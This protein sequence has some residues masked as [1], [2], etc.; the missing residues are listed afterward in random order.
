MS[1]IKLFTELLKNM[2]N[3]YDNNTKK[4]LIS[5]NKIIFKRF[6]NYYIILLKNNKLN[7]FLEII[8]HLKN[9]EPNI[10]YITTEDILFFNNLITNN[11]ILSNNIDLNEFILLNNIKEKITNKNIFSQFINDIKHILVNDHIETFKKIDDFFDNYETIL[12]KVLKKG[13][14][15]NGPFFDVLQ[16]DNNKI[17]EINKILDNYKTKKK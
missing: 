7:S 13:E 12:C 6:L 15:F 11:I 5:Y 9:I 1:E 17:Q 4:T 8:N 10:K 16:V 2:C 14:N 3:I